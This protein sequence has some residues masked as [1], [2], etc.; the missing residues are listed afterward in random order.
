[1]SWEVRL[2][3]PESVLSELAHTLVSGDVVVA[4]SDDGP[5][6]LRSTRF[7]SLRDASAVRHEADSI[8]EVISGLARVH[9]QSAHRLAIDNVIEVLR[10]GRRNTFVRLGTASMT[11]SAPPVST[12][13]THPDG[14]T[15]TRRRS[16]P[17]LPGVAKALTNDAM[18][19]DLNCAAS[20]TPQTVLM[21]RAMKRVMDSNGRSR[22]RTRC[23]FQRLG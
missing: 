7:D 9:L 8:V 17:V 3:G 1:M 20:S 4:R 18:A 21:Q 19:R 13:V 11:L 12:V 22:Q 10:D 16:D 14:T 15:E 23:C 5:Y 2:L 6:T